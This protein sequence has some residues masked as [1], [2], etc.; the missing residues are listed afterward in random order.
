MK[1]LITLASLLVPLGVLQAQPSPPPPDSV[2]VTGRG[3]VRVPNTRAVIS[4]GLHAA[5]PDENAVRDDVSRRSQTVSEALKKSGAAR[6]QTGSVSINPE[7]SHS[8]PG[9]RVQPPKIT[10]YTAQVTMGFEV[11]VEDA[12]RVITAA[13]EAG[14]NSVA[15]FQTQPSEEARRAAEK[16]ALTAAVKDAEA[17]ARTVLS[18]AGLDWA[19]VRSIDATG[20]GAAPF[21]MPRAAM[22][23]APSPELQIEAGE[24]VVSREVTMQVGFQKP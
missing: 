21:A 24:T 5:G 6:L 13:V 19:G 2:S 3:E 23:S 16:D 17:Q 9:P 12:G 20:G 15:N 4:L 18:T 8:E 7:F 1:L 11:P 22:M 10:G 14:A